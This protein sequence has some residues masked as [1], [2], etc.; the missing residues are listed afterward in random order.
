MLVAFTGREPAFAQVGLKAEA[1]RQSTRATREIRS[2]QGWVPLSVQVPAAQRSEPV[3]ITLRCETPVAEE[4]TVFCAAPVAEWRNP[5]IELARFVGRSFRAHGARGVLARLRTHASTPPDTP[6]PVY[7]EWLASQ[8]PA[9]DAL[10]RMRRETDTLP[11]RPRFAI[12]LTGEGTPQAA[13]RS[14]ASLDEQVYRRWELWV[15]RPSL[16]PDAIDARPD[17]HQCAGGTPAESLNSAASLS[18]ADFLIV[19]EAGDLLA[20]EALFELAACAERSPDAD[21]IYSD[22]DT[23]GPEGP[24]APQFKPAWSPEYLLS[25]MYLGRPLAIRRSL[26]LQVGGYRASVDEGL[27][28]DIALRATA[29]SDRVQHVDR[30]LYHRA[31]GRPSAA[32]GDG[33][34]RILEAFV[35]TAAPA[36][37]VI[38]EGHAGGWRVQYALTRTPDVTIV[39][40]TDGRSASKDG[41]ASLLARCLGSIV[42][43]TTYAPYRLL[44]ADNG[45]LPP[46]AAKILASIPH[47]RVTYTWSGPFN[48]PRKINFAVAH[49]ASEFVLLLNDDVE[50]INGGW[51]TALMEY[52]QQAGIGAVGAKLFY[53]DGRL[54]HVGVATGVCGVAAHLLHQAPG[55]TAGC[56]NIATAVRNC[57]AVTGACLL[58]RRALYDEVGGFDER[59]AVDFNDVDF[60]LKVRAAGYRIVFTPYARLYH[61]ESGSFGGRVQNAEDVRRMREMWGATL[62]HDPYYNPNLSRD[63]P[64]CRLG[65]RAARER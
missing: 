21:V 37:A 22:E 55:H 39:I 38:S 36:S 48:F 9:A 10:Q 15:C 26:V 33:E 35:R 1:G 65:V 2:S 5:S 51:L 53:P 50:V 13:T 29:G 28:F 42:E 24:E 58:T 60:C 57:S 19:S 3:E 11:L 54:Q 4:A 17:V 31:A 23:Q 61:H 8:A 63:F 30:V 14:L 46:D 41:G 44:I 43:S 6:A 62:D 25:R 59:L 27:E 64:D 45:V 12:L 49:S 7:R 20:P 56:G 18:T 16:H 52:G 47:E 40:P 32:R 34:R